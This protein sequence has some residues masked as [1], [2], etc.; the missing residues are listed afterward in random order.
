[1]TRIPHLTTTTKTGR[2]VLIDNSVDLCADTITLDSTNT[3]SGSSPT[4]WIRPGNVVAYY[5][6]GGNFVEA[7]DANA[8]AAT[9]PSITTSGHGDATADIVIVGNHGTISVTVSTGTGTEANC[10]TDLNADQAFAANYIASSA[11]GELTITSLHTGPEEWFYIDASTSDTYGFA[12]GIA[13][14]VQGTDPDIRV[15]LDYV[16]LLDEFGNAID[17]DVLAARSGHFDESALINLTPEAKAVLSRRGS[18][19]G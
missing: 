18:I 2:S 16:S 7:N 4:S 9:A 6:S 14:A 12:E 8:D 11:A 1:M 15:V 17:G 10:A 19:F 5:T 13:N 3:D